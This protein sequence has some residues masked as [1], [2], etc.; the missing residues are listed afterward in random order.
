MLQPNSTPPVADAKPPPPA[1]PE[2]EGARREVRAALAIAEDEDRPEIG[3]EGRAEIARSLSRALR[4][5]GQ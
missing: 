3:W 2:L 1:R 5:L 4:L